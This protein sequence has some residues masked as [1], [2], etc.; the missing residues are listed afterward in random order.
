MQTEKLM[1]IGEQEFKIVKFHAM[2]QFRLARKLAGLFGAL[3]K[4]GDVNNG[5]AQAG[6]F[7]D[8]LAE[9]SDKE[10]DDLFLTLFKNTYIKEPKGLGYSPLVNGGHLMYENLD[11]AVFAYLGWE[12]IVLNLQNFTQ[13]ISQW[14]A[15][16]G[17]Q[18][19]T[20]K[21]LNS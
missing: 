3:V 13:Q 12:V 14:A 18:V 20:L 10:A 6:L 15:Q 4:S 8:R 21:A 9:M 1:T 17:G 19:P 7:L 2:D 11:L 16:R 5:L